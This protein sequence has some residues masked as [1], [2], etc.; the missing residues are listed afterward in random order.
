MRH[1]HGPLDG[2]RRP[3]RGRC[4]SSA[5]AGCA[6][7]PARSAVESARRDVPG[8]RRRSRA[9]GAPP[10]GG[11]RRTSA[12]GAADSAAPDPRRRGRPTVLG[13]P[14]GHPQRE[15]AAARWQG[16]RR[17]RPSC[18]RS[19]KTLRRRR[20][21]PAAVDR[22]ATA[23]ARAA[24]TAT[25]GRAVHDRPA[26]H[27]LGHRCSSRSRSS[28]RSAPSAE[29]L[30][31]VLSE[32]SADD[33]VTQQHVDLKARLTN[34][35]AEEARLRTFF[36]QAKSVTDMLAIERELARVRGDIES[37][38]A[39][40]HD[41]GASGRDGDAHDRARRARADRAARP[42][43]STGA[44]ATRCAT[45]SR[46][47]SSW[48]CCGLITCA[49]RALAARGRLACRALLRDPGGGHPARKRARSGPAAGADD[50]SGHPS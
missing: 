43:G 32:S 33:D 20:R 29:K 34:A 3:A 37:M 28:T 44:S 17:R 27:G 30:G 38:T 2:R 6:R 41:D 18:A 22:H 48:S 39:Q 15:R 8:G 25:P 11:V 50:G 12:G 46:R 49:D 42:A 31:K 35:K 21:E 23:G 9:P 10:D 13:R 24:P 47:Q 16:A 7:A 1:V 5:L 19:R 45:A 36:D 40:L 4:S 26:L 14:A